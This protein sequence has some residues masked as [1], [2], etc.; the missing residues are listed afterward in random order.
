MEI[1]QGSITEASVETKTKLTNDLIRLLQVRDKNEGMAKD[2]LLFLATTPKFK[3]LR[4]GEIYNAFKMAMARELLDAEG[5]EFNLLPELSINMTSKVLISYFEWKK[6]NP[7]C[8]RAKEH[9]LKL[10]Q[11]TSPSDE[12]LKKIREDF[13]LSTFKDI[14][15]RDY[16]AD[17]WIL[18]EDIE[19]KL[20]QTIEQKKNLYKQQEFIYIQELKK[21]ANKNQG[22][23]SYTEA[24]ENAQK[25]SREG[26]RL[27]V[28]QNRC[29]AIMVC[30]YLKQFKNDYE[31]FKEAINGTTEQKRKTETTAT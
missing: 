20:S 1:S 25:N 30:N 12:E 13:I 19:Q 17:A 7:E 8:Q 6:T 9:L 21:D 27:A 4:P 24:F 15:E 18:Y 23:R 28:V 26:K 3:S 16:S 5:K 14:Q 2:W 31:K 29:R 11:P 10:N 22:R